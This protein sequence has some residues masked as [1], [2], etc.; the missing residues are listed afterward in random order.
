[1]NLPG[2]R[3]TPSLM[4]ALYTPAFHFAPDGTAYGGFFRDGRS[5]SLVDQAQK[6]FLNAFEMANTDATAL[7][8]R[9]QMRP[10]YAQL[11][12]VFGAAVTADPVQT[13]AAV[14]AAL[15]AYETE[16]PEFHPFSS[17]YDAYQNGKASLSANE[18]QGLQLFNDP[19]KGNCTACH[20][21][22][23]NNGVPALFTDFSYDNVG[24]PRNWNIPANAADTALPYVPGN[25]MALGSPNY[26]YYD[27]GL[28][29]PTR[30][31]LVDRTQRCGA[32]K[33]PTLRNVAIKQHYFHNGVF[34]N[35]LDVVTWYA[36][37]DTNPK[38]W[39]VQADGITPDIP[40]NDV[41]AIYQANVNVAEVP[42]NPGLAPTLSAAEI[43]KIV[44]FLCTLTD[45]YDPANPGAY[46]KQPQC[47]AQ[48]SP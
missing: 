23:S 44:I 6:P 9:L 40:Y 20:V 1:M 12:S 47:Q 39:Y 19:T 37:R 34:S 38:R 7:Q 42:Y 29:G 36:T 15:A 17:K 4:Y 16:G 18:L 21:T 32:F 43:G 48:A 41:P 13:L 45:G 14:G 10:Y 5:P 24:I 2:L 22:T 27:L 33:V 46:G 3:N 35:L 30:T 26:R 31:D 25:G 28:C 8:Q 11:Q